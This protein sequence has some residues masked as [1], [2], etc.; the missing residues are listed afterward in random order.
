[1]S[2]VR[3]ALVF[4]VAF[5][6][7]V[8]AQGNIY[9]FYP[10]LVTVRG[11]LVQLREQAASGGT[12]MVLAIRLDADIVVKPS[13]NARDKDIDAGTY[14]HVRVVQVFFP[15]MLGDK[16]ALK[17]LGHLITVRGTFS[18]RI[19]PGQFTDVTM[20]VKSYSANPYQ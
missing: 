14:P 17:M 20:D 12:V 4:L 15:G 6:T 19:A 10:D 16:K 5:Q 1:M 8:R 11:R 3:W 18:E 2:F 7:P 9:T 13:P